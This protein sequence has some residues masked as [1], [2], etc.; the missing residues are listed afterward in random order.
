[1]GIKH[2]QTWRTAYQRSLKRHD[3]CCIFLFNKDSILDITKEYSTVCNMR[4]YRWLNYGSYGLNTVP[5]TRKFHE[6]THT[7]SCVCARKVWFLH[8]P[9]CIDFAASIFNK[10]L[11]KKLQIPIVSPLKLFD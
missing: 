5:P 6:N 10:N 1:M 9:R 11:L 3:Y 8:C 7:M 2:Q 4:P